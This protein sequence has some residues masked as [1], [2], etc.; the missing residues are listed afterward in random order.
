MEELDDQTLVINEGMLG[1]L[2]MTLEEV[3]LSVWGVVGGEEDLLLM[4][5]GIG[6]QGDAA[7]GG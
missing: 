5:M 3:S 1:T 4:V 7:A 6:A 2:K